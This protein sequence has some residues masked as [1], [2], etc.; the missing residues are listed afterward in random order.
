MRNAKKLR[1][2]ITNFETGLNKLTMNTLCNIFKQQHNKLWG[3][4]SSLT[5]MLPEYPASIRGGDFNTE[6]RGARS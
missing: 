3:Q 4:L 5:V 1:V 6:A 2:K